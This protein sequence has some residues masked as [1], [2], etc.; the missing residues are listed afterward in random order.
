[1]I[2]WLRSL[3][4]GSP[5]EYRIIRS[6]PNEEREVIERGLQEVPDPDLYAIE[7]DLDPGTYRCQAI[8]DNKFGEMEWVRDVGNPREAREVERLE[9]ELRELRSAVEGA[10]SSRAEAAGSFDD[11]LKKATIESVL[12]GDLEVTDA[13]QI[14]S[15]SA[16]FDGGGD[17]SLA[18]SVEDPRDLGEIAGRSVLQFLDDPSQVERL[19]EAGGRLVDGFAGAVEEGAHEQPDDAQEGDDEVGSDDWEGIDGGPTTLDD[20][21]APEAAAAL[22]LEDDGKDGPTTL[23][24]V[25][26]RDQGDEVE[27]P[28]PIVSEADGDQE[29]VAD[30]G[31]EDDGGDPSEKDVAEAI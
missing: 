27:D 11:R 10:S 25:K 5:D 7:H 17:G 9:R 4:R 28:A 3:L 16:A 1:M 29:A 14:A 6:G 24:D 21:K 30:G 20:L 31:E 13:K 2:E 8:R 18:E 12:D 22:D 19:G 26:E 23:D 15:L